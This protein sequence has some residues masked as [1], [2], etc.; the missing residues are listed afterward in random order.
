MKDL[1]LRRH[2]EISIIEPDSPLFPRSL[3]PSVSRYDC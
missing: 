2:P 1:Y 3:H